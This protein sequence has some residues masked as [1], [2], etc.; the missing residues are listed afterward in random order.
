MVHI[1][2]SMWSKNKIQS[3]GAY[4]LSQEI[5][6]LFMLILTNT[7]SGAAQEGWRKEISDQQKTAFLQ[8]E[9]MS[10]DE[11]DVILSLLVGADFKRLSTG[12]VAVTSSGQ[13]ITVLGYSSDPME[14]ND[15]DKNAVYKQHMT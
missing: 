5:A 6:N 13:T 15:S 2:S 12:D 8:I 10:C 4:E 9:K 1:R 3:Q 7:D 14:V 11:Q